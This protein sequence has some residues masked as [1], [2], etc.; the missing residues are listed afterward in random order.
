MMAKFHA[1][2][3]SGYSLE[4]NLWLNLASEI[5]LSETANFVYNFV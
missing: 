2:V 1:D 5:E 4:I 3:S